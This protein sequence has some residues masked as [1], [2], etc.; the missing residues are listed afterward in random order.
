MTYFISAI[1]DDDDDSLSN[2]AKALD[3]KQSHDLNV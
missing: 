1:N 3:R 2:V